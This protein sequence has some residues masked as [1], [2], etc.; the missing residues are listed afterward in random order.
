MATTN[1]VGNSL[2]GAT[3]SGAFVGQTSPT[4]TTPRIGQIN[5]TNGLGVLT[6]TPI[7]SA[8][9]SVEIQN[10]ATLG[11]LQIKASGTDTNISLVLLAKGSG[12]VAIEGGD[13]GTQPVFFYNGT[14]LQHS[15]N[16]TFA[17][18]AASRTVTWPD[19]NGTVVF[20]NVGQVVASVSSANIT[21]SASTSVSFVDVTSASL[22]I[23]PTS[24]SNKVL[25]IITWA[26]AITN[27]AATNT[28][29][30][31]Q[32]L[33][34]STVIPTGASITIGAQSS[35]GGTGITGSGASFCFLDSPATT[36]STTY[37]LQHKSSINTATA[38]S[39]NVTITLMEIQG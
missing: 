9:N 32:V 19:A 16:F 10:S 7:A 13:G 18:T 28:S 33:R 30:T 39:A 22:A 25:V 31:S 8:V 36:S 20:S 38:T 27:V 6:L 11:A 37:K 15:T 2:T 24:A 4:I 26:A 12:A 14:S 35:T 5:D 17:N 29:Y 1:A 21:G 3:G 23:T 34:A